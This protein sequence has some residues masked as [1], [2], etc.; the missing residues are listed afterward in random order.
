MRFYLGSDGH[1]GPPQAGAFRFQSGVGLRQSAIKIPSWELS[2]Q[3][4]KQD[5]PTRQACVVQT[6]K[7]PLPN[8]QIEFSA[9][10]KSM[11]TRMKGISNPGCRVPDKQIEQPTRVHS[12]KPSKVKHRRLRCDCGRPAVKVLL[13]RVGSDPQYTVHLPL[14]R[15]CLELEHSMQEA[16]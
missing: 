6:L 8:R 7:P 4:G 15:D 14:C 10:V 1:A 13:V 5:P 16:D 2:Y 11:R 9:S 12:H 3:P